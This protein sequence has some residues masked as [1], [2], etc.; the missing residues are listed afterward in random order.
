MSDGLRDELAAALRLNE[1]PPI[2]PRGYER[3][4]E[5][6]LPVV[7]RYAAQQLRDAADEPDM[8]DVFGGPSVSVSELRARAD[9]LEAGE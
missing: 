3:Q 6:L 9:A 1:N 7:R 5:N 2:W 4:L 8:D